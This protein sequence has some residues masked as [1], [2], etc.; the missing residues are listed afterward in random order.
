MK[1]LCG[2][3]CAQC[4]LS[5]SCP[6]CA[7]TGGRPFG[8]DCMLAACS[9]RKGQQGCGPCSGK[10]CQLKEQLI[11]EFNALGI[12]DMEEVRDLNALAGSYINLEYTLPSG[13]TFKLWDDARIYFGNQLCKKGSGRCYGLTADER[14]LLVCEYGPDG[15]DPE[16]VVFKR[17]TAQ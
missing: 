17:R 16:I 7:Q 14:Y 5:A 1:T 4:E 9:K 10:S 12:A 2:I 3:D 11:A 15:S 6:G 8:G 13:Q